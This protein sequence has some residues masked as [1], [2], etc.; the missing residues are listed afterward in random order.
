MQR[1]RR[2]EPR[3]RVSGSARRLAR[4]FAWLCVVVAARDPAVAR[5]AD[6]PSLEWRAPAGCPAQASVEA[7]LAAR[8]RETPAAARAELRCARRRG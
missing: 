5:A 7:A 3:S 6:E 2:V 4:V 1:S 8:L